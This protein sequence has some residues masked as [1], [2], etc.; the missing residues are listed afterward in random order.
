MITP[1]LVSALI[2]FGALVVSLVS[3]NKT[4]K[5]NERQNELAATTDRL[6]KMLIEREA[7]EAVAGKK[8]DLSANIYKAGKHD[9]RM[10]VF[11]R[12]KGVARNVRIVDLH[13]GNDTILLDS[14]IAR[15]F[16][17]PILEQHQSVELI[18]AISLGSPLR[19]HIKL[20]WDDEIGQSHE[21]E[22]TP[23]L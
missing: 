15:K 19:A 4:N 22:L 11:N 5:F 14:E 10:K 17:V 13:G 12:G 6:N 7:A 9:Y 1:D 21:K 2:A 8:A 20:V 3:L 16:P 18:A 23:S